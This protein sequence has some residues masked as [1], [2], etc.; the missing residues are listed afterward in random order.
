MR[1][2]PYGLAFMLGYYAFR[3]GDELW[4]RINNGWQY[5][6]WSEIYCKDSDPPNPAVTLIGPNAHALPTSPCLSGQANAAGHTEFTR[7][8]QIRQASFPTRTIYNVNK[9][10]VYTAG[11][12]LRYNRGWS[13]QIA[14]AG[15]NAPLPAQYQPYEDALTRVVPRFEGHTA[16]WIEYYVPDLSPV[17]PT[18]GL[19]PSPRP[20]RG[21]P[22]LPRPDTPQQPDHGYGAQPAP[23]PAPNPPGVI[24]IIEPPVEFPT[25][26]PEINWGPALVVGRVTQ[27]QNGTRLDSTTRPNQNQQYHR[28]R[29]PPPRVKESKVR[30]SR[31]MAFMWYG[32]GQFTEYIDTVNVLYEALPKSVKRDLYQQYGR[33]PNPAERARIVYERL[34]EIDVPKAITSYVREQ[35]EDRIYAAGGRQAGQAARD[36]NRP[37]GYEAGGS[38]T[39]GGEYVEGIS[40]TRPDWWPDWLPWS[41]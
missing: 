4:Q 37:I 13:Y 7:Q 22:P 24:E 26:M 5:P 10:F 31:G 33:Q 8:P 19:T 34:N 17:H 25:A 40:D 29:R 15:A 39:G 6:G 28:A 27:N 32:I 14:I 2:G 21:S 41:P 23:Q 35:M 12:S 36:A 38:L 9:W 16:P 20:V 30:M 18:P 1:L 3:A 11:A